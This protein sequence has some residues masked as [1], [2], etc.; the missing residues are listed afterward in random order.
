MST[1]TTTCPVPTLPKPPQRAKFELKSP[2]GA[3][4]AT[5]TWTPQGGRKPKALVVIVH[6]GGWHSGYFDQL[7]THLASEQ[8]YVAAYDQPGCGW[9]DPDPIAP[10]GFFHVDSIK[11]VTDDIYASV[12]WAKKESGDETL[13]LFLLGESYGGVQVLA[14][15]YE[16]NERNVKLD[17]VIILGGLIRVGKKI[18]PPKPVVKILLLLARYFPRMK[19]PTDTG[20]TFDEA[21]GDKRWADVARDDDKVT[22]SMKCTLG[23][24]I[25]VITT[26]DKMLEKAD[27]FPV[28]LLAIHGKRDVRTQFEPV[29]E[30][31]DRAGVNAELLPIETD[32]HQLLQDT[33]EVTQEVIDKVSS[34]VLETIG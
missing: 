20:G 12:E 8:I 33:R 7:G 13:P 2:R 27:D 3:S 23:M 30:F 28:P 21:F 9:S 15:A 34:W 18:L 17:G 14:G 16:A 25:S 11:D 19:M 22:V 29:V 31:V 24:A 6:G 1:T 4:L 26:G 32:G 5:R 10:D